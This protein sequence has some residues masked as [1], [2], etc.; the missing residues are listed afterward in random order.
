MSFS[1]HLRIPALLLGLV[2]LGGCGS[3]GG[4]ESR[5]II[6]AAPPAEGTTLPENGQPEP[7][8]EPPPEDVAMDLSTASRILGGGYAGNEAGCYSL[9]NHG[10]GSSDIAYIDY[11]AL[12]MRLLE[13]PEKA[14]DSLQGR[15]AGIHSNASPVWAGNHLFLFRQRGTEALLASQGEGAHAAI[16][17]LK[18]DGSAPETLTLPVRLT[19]NLSS[20]VLWDGSSL[21][22][23]GQDSGEDSLHY[24][25]LQLDTQSMELTELH[26][27]PDGYEYSIEGYWEKGPL[28]Q[29]AGN[30]PP[31]DDPAFNESWDNRGFTLFKH[32]MLSG[33]RQDVF[34]WTQG[35]PVNVQGA[36][37]Y[38]YSGE[39]DTLYQLNANTGEEAA[40]AQGLSPGDYILAQIQPVMLDGLV[41]LQFSANQGRTQYLYTIDPATGTVNQPPVDRLGDNITVLAEAPEFFVVKNGDKWVRR[42]LVDAGYDP[43]ANP[44][45]DYND[46]FVS[47]SE[48]GLIQKADYWA[49]TR[50]FT[51]IKD[52][53]YDD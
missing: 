46:K 6:M 15:L 21:Y 22:F 2:L 34:S 37:V 48:Y 32:G 1:K 4:S 44:T 7:E 39:A 3:N 50:S 49:G 20:A 13:A 42:E 5:S 12:E 16:I 43:V 25:L 14:D 36:T 10:D 28:V 47:V 45:G 51:A 29:A 18:A 9:L 17:R 31:N 41:R 19:L 26:R 11:A 53:I 23:I 27:F 38:H 8:E 52:L 30:L 33:S 40:I 35:T 24:D